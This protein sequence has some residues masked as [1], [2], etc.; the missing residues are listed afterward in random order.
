MNTIKSEVR[1]EP[2]LQ[3]VSSFELQPVPE[4]G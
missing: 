3:R 4:A 2:R 1:Y